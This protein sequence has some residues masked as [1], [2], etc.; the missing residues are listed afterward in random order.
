MNT[1]FCTMLTCSILY[2]IS[3]VA[4]V[5][6]CLQGARATLDGCAVGDHAERLAEVNSRGLVVADTKNVPHCHPVDR[7]TATT[8]GAA[9]LATAA[10]SSSA[11]SPLA[12][13]SH[14]PACAAPVHHGAAAGSAGSS[15]A[16]SGTA[17]ATAA[18]AASSAV[19]PPVV[20]QLASAAGSV[21]KN[22]A[23]H[24]G[25]AAAVNAAAATAPT[26]SSAAAKPAIKARTDSKWVAYP[27]V[28]WLEW[29]QDVNERQV[30]FG[31][32][33]VLFR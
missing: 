6:V 32:T 16:V 5:V 1:V 13:Q 22:P 11:A 18:A 7:K 4:E 12:A 28:Q 15:K 8:E 27:P 23:V 14:E 29:P 24:D 33:V 9:G 19:A 21:G 17:A 26:A 10:A 3:T 25:A 31:A 20:N 2:S 30:S